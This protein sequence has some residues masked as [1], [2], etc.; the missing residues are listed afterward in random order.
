MHCKTHGIWSPGKTTAHST[1]H[2]TLN[3]SEDKQYRTFTLITVFIMAWFVI[4]VGSLP[5]VSPKTL[6]CLW[7]YCVSRDSRVKG[8][9]DILGYCFHVQN[10]NGDNILV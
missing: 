8:N 7:S 6:V 4:W 9:P 10:F 3:K 2:K 5:L 1:S